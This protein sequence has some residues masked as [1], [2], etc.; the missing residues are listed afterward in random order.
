MIH[1]VMEQV[2]ARIRFP[3]NPGAGIL[4]DGRDRAKTA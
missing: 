3:A 4:G 1:L 2:W